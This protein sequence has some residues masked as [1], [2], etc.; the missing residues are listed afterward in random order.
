MYI[1]HL[2]TKIVKQFHKI[3]LKFLKRLLSNNPPGRIRIRI[4]FESAS[5]TIT[6]LLKEKIAI[7][8]MWV[9]PDSGLRI[10][11]ITEYSNLQYYTIRTCSVRFDLEKTSQKLVID[12][13]RVLK[14]VPV[15]T[16]P[17][18]DL[19]LFESVPWNR[20]T[21]SLTS[22]IVSGPQKLATGLLGASCI[23]VDIDVVKKSNQNLFNIS[24]LFCSIP[25]FTFF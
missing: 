1:E 22:K 14:A 21:S 2:K 19:D 13:Q 9:R 25:F 24:N 20:V 18:L 6:I 17:I 23:P 12:P 11:S 7:S 4:F 16:V 15:G 8:D 10:S 3:F 5:L